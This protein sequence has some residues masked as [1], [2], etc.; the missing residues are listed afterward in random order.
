MGGPDPEG[1]S[2]SSLDSMRP[3][4]SRERCDPE[5]AERVAPRPAR[6][7]IPALLARLRVDAAT[8]PRRLQLAKFG[9]VAIIRNRFRAQVLLNA[10]AESGP[11]RT[12]EEDAGADL[13]L[14]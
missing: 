12:R 7:G 6:E 4:A 13:A 2:E 9:T 10:F 1:S 11:L 8:A 14:V 3:A 5:E